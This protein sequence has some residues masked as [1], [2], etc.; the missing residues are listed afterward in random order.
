MKKVSFVKVTSITL[1]CLFLLFGLLFA[2]SYEW[3]RPDVFELK[4]GNRMVEDLRYYYSNPRLYEKAYEHNNRI[5][6][7]RLGITIDDNGWKLDYPVSKTQGG[8]AAGQDND[9]TIDMPD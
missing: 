4:Y 8:T 6:G 2:Q 1:A 9:G 3:K 7:D 5:R